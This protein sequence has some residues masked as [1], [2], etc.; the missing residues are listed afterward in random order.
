VYQYECVA[1]IGLFPSDGLQFTYVSKKQLKPSDHMNP[2][3]GNA[4]IRSPV[5]LLCASMLSWPHWKKSKAVTDFSR[6]FHEPLSCSLFHFLACTRA[7]LSH[8]TKTDIDSRISGRCTVRK[9]CTYVY[10]QKVPWVHEQ[11]CFRFLNI[12]IGLKKS[13]IKYA[14]VY[15]YFSLYF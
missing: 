6:C 9:S 4:G 15:I 14:C 7:P 3:T 12:F 8:S 11:P 1:A 10:M 2:T 5:R 13:E